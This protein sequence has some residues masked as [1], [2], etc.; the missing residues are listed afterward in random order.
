MDLLGCNHE[1]QL[2]TYGGQ[3]PQTIQ[4][5]P[6]YSLMHDTKYWILYSKY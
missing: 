3:P 6:Q 4:S 2:W 5:Q 1:C